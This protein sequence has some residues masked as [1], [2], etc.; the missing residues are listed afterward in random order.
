ML[1]AEHFN[2]KTISA[3]SNDSLPTLIQIKAKLLGYSINISICE[4]RGLLQT[5]SKNS[6]VYIQYLNSTISKI[7]LQKLVIFNKT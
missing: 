3:S 1:D 4:V 6:E 7:K 2:Y 5:T